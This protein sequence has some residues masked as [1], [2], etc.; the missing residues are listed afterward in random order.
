M[1][2]YQEAEVTIE[3]A[4]GFASAGDRKQLAGTYGME[5]VGDGYLKAGNKTSAARAYRRALEL[6]PGNQR[7]EQKLSKAR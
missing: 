2:R 1:E 3:R 6:D 4:L 7:L 5:G